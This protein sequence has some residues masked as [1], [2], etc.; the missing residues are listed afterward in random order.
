MRDRVCRISYSGLSLVDVSRMVRLINREI[1]LKTAK[2]DG[3]SLCIDT[4]KTEVGRNVVRRR[5]CLGI[6]SWHFTIR[7]MEKFNFMKCTHLI[8]CY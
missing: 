7:Q 1:R 8:T 2:L 5:K 6:F 3:C 4:P